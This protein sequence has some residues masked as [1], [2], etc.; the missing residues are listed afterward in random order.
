MIAAAQCHAARAYAAVH[1]AMEEPM[2]QAS[3]QPT[4]EQFRKYRASKR[5]AVNRIVRCIHAGVI[6]LSPW[7]R[8]VLARSRREH[9][10]SI[11]RERHL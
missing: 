7:A 1:H 2:P 9:T 5:E 3:S 10:A 4:G 8:D 11:N 6:A